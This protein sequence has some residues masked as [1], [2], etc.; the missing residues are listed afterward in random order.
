MLNLVSF[1]AIN[2]ECSCTDSPGQDAGPSQVPSQQCWHAFAAA[3]PRL[4]KRPMHR[5]GIEPTTVVSGV[6]HPNQSTT[7]APLV[8]LQQCIILVYSFPHV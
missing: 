2:L 3:M 8:G 1:S 5:V 6:Q 7:A 4:E